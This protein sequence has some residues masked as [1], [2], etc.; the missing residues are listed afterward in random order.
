MKSANKQLTEKNRD[1]KKKEQFLKLLE[2][3]NAT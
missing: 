2:D 1:L 3:L